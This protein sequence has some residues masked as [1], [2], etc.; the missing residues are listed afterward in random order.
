MLKRALLGYQKFQSGHEKNLHDTQYS[1]G[2]VFEK[3][4]RLAEAEI[5]FADAHVG[6]AMLLG[7]NDP[8]TWNQVDE[9]SFPF[10]VLQPSQAS[11]NLLGIK[12]LSIY[13]WPRFAASAYSITESG[14]K[15]RRLINDFEAKK[16]RF[17]AM[18]LQVHG[19]K[20]E[21]NA[22]AA[23]SAV[24]EKYSSGFEEC[25]RLAEAENAFADARAGYMMLLGPNDPKTVDAAYC[26]DR[27][28][29]KQNQYSSH[30]K[31]QKDRVV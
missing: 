4:G 2:E 19:P 27:I 16:N 29:L 14:T 10:A 22:F 24:L 31:S 1:L 5:F 12:V 9:T 25:G 28:R 17:Q 11:G 8:K 26:L 23:Y 3:C 7:P 18:Q 21:A 30:L 20:D 15:P 6:Y 13:A